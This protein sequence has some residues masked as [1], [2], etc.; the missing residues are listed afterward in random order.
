[1]ARMR[2]ESLLQNKDSD[3]V[4]SF[5]EIQ[6]NRSALRLKHLK[7]PL[8]FELIDQV[9]NFIQDETGLILSSDE[10][11]TLIQSYPDVKSQIIEH[12]LPD[13]GSRDE[14]LNMIFDFFLG[15][16]RPT[17]GD[18]VCAKSVIQI[19]HRQAQRLGYKVNEDN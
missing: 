12:P 7:S 16:H 11:E 14:V 19:L 5:L 6:R 4:D 9:A 17:I 8:P 10:T 13:T 2:I 3:L 18:N 1:M 15:T